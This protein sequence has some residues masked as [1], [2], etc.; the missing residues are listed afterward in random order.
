LLICTVLALITAASGACGSG[1]SRGRAT[2]DAPMLAKPSDLTAA[3]RKWGVGPRR[4]PNV[5]YQPDVV[6]IDEGPDAV[7]GLA[8]NGVEWIIDGESSQAQDVQPGKI[9]FATSRVVGRVLHTRKEGDDVAVLIGPV[10]LTDVV[11]DL[12]VKFEAPI[13]FGEAIEYPA[14]PPG[15]DGAPKPQASI[16]RFGTYDDGP[17]LVLA[18]APMAPRQR[19]FPIVSRHGLGIRINVEGDGS[20]FDGDA[21]FALAD[22]LLEVD[23][24]ISG[25][26][27]TKAVLRLKGSAG[28]AFG[29][30]A[31]TDRGLKGN[32]DIVEPSLPTDL[33]IPISGPHFPMTVSLRQ[34]FSVETAWGGKGSL[35]AKADFTASGAYDIG[36][37]NG[38]FGPHGP[39]NFKWTVHPLA[40]FG[41]TSAAHTGLVM[42]YQTKVIV[43]IGG[44][45]FAT[46]PYLRLH[47]GIGYSGESKLQQLR[48]CRNASITVSLGAGFGYFLPQALVNGINAVLRALNLGA[49]RSEGGIEAV[50]KKLLES[51][52]RV[53]PIEA[54]NAN[55]A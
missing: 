24:D 44:L 29:F 52:T 41:H 13:D 3:E 20:H 54:C 11:S 22:P 46:G 39:T 47:T 14:F 19:A 26:K 51:Y 16:D 21:T 18:R 12:K 40:S 6:L 32:F 8:S 42:A 10:E 49:I 37:S 50:S 31:S 55:G 38:S 45:G 15:L 23:L 17:R 48:G 25:G 35:S 33:S 34:G 7:V 28:L 36:W 2:P 30:T 1:G 27:I 53:P 4:G 5:T 9:L 43:G